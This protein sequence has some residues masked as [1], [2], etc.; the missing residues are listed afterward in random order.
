MHVIGSLAEHGAEDGPE[1]KVL[2]TLFLHLHLDLSDT[3]LR[4]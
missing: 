1:F 4:H 2:L 3:S